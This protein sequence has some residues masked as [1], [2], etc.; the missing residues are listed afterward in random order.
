VLALCSAIDAGDDSALPI[1]ADAL[2]E[3]GDPRA[4]GVRLVVAGRYEPARNGVGCYWTEFD[5]EAGAIPAAL[6]GRA[7]RLRLHRVWTGSTLHYDDR[8]AAYLALAEALADGQ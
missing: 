4:D 5:D 7:I 2:E 6:F 3:A 1:L 8:S